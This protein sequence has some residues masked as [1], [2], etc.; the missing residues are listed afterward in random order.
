MSLPN[1]NMTLL[2]H[3]FHVNLQDTPAHLLFFLSYLASCFFFFFFT[4]TMWKH[5]HPCLRI[6]TRLIVLTKTKDLY[7]RTTVQILSKT[8]K[9]GKF[10]AERG[11]F[12]TRI[13]SW[14]PKRFDWFKYCS[15]PTLQ[16]DWLSVL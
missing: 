4:E 14:F 8:K 1:N 13:S 10:N 9:G 7:N 12:R 16:F 5:M 6:A 11:K 15:G 2:N 3:L